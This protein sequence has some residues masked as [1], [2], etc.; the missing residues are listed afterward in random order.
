MLGTINCHYTLISSSCMNR[1][2]KRETFLHI[3]LY[4][5]HA[6]FLSMLYIEHCQCRKD[7]IPGLQSLIKDLIACYDDNE[8]SCTDHENAQLLLFGECMSLTLMLG[9]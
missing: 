6:L 2:R 5:D 3:I 9:S 8:N 4:S 7:G 1:N